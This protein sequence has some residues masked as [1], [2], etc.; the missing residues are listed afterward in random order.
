MQ[1]S[2][3][4][5]FGNLKEKRLV[6]IPASQRYKDT[7]KRRRTVALR[8][9]NGKRKKAGQVDLLKKSDCWEV[10]P[11]L[12]MKLKWVRLP[13]CLTNN[14]FMLV[15]RLLV[16]LVQ[17]DGSEL[18]QAA[19]L[20]LKWTWHQMDNVFVHLLWKCGIHRCVTIRLS[21]T[22]DAR[23]IKLNISAG[24]MLQQPLYNHF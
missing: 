15:L 1:L 8:W 23:K 16:L 6:G 5:T 14:L 20:L 11:R 17:L 24:G 2:D 10:R 12:R 4:Q 21:A 13:L 19:S 7:N 18:E 22:P 9:R 3:K